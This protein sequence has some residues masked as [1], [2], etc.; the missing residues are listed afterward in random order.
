MPKWRSHCI[1]LSIILIDSVLNMGK[2][3]Y[4]QL[5]LEECTYIFKET[6]YY[7]LGCLILSSDES[8]E[9]KSYGEG[10][11]DYHEE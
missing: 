11:K 6:K 5:F 1:C 8:D 2:N 7:I 10:K 9:K 3:Y 4:P